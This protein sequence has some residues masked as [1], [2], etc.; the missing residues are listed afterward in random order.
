MFAWVTYLRDTSFK[1]H[2]NDRND[3]IDISEEIDIN[4]TNAPKDC[5]ICHYWYFKDIGFKYEPYL[6]NG[7]YDLIQKVM[8][9]NDAAIAYVKGSAYR[10]NLW[11][12]SKNDTVGIINNSDLV[13]K[14]G[15]L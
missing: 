14:N 5:D 12:M 13:D 4:N 2:I 7:C 8:I 6:F 11:Y 10:I 1:R 9:F 15:V 3:R